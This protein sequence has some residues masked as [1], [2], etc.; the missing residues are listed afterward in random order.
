MTN[1]SYFLDLL[2]LSILT[3]CS[4]NTH[5][6]FRSLG[7][8]N[9]KKAAMNA[10]TNEQYSDA[11]KQLQKHL[12]NSAQDWEAQGMLANACLKLVGIDEFQLIKIS[13]SSGS[14]GGSSN[15]L[16][17]SQYFP[18]PTEANL[19]LL[20]LASESLNKIPID[21]RTSDQ[22]YYLGLIEF[23]KS[24]TLAK[25]L[26]DISGQPSIEKLS[27]LTEEDAQTI[28]TSIDSASTVLQGVGADK[29]GNISEVKQNILDTPGATL[30]DK[31]ST[32]VILQGG[33]PTQV[34]PGTIL[35][36]DQNIMPTEG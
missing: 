2:I 9:P 25:K 14:S 11:V 17:M 36:T 19:S 7:E 27:E 23:S 3:S 16:A 18:D 29:V 24:L 34:P 4:S 30:K 32:Y 5:N 21:V 10:L 31:I 15:F 20:N 35:P 22:T 6:V 28:F 1:K 12:I 33:D 13:L 8:T 26:V